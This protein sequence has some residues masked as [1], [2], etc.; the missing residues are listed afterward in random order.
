MSCYALSIGNYSS[1]PPPIWK[2]KGMVSKGFI[3]EAIK[4]GYSFDEIWDL[5]DPSVDFKFTDKNIFEEDTH[6]RP[7][8]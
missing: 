2:E 6:D 5:I 8:W 1:H 3:K 4:L 7:T